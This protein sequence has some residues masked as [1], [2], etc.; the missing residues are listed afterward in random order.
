MNT[1]WP[2]YTGAYTGFWQHEW[3]KHGTCLTTYEKSVAGTVTTQ[4]DYFAK[5][6]E[7]RRDCN[8]LAALKSVGITPGTSAA[9]SDFQSAITSYCGNR[10]HLDCSGSDLSEAWICYDK[11]FNQ[12]DC[13]LADTCPSTVTLP[14]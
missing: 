7:L 14:A 8:V 2:S 10:A 9:L 13:L 1:Y 11:D 5:S 4:H 3:D 12:M 6:L